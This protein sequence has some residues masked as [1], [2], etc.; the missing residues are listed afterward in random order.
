VVGG[1]VYLFV[2]FVVGQPLLRRI[3][4][5]ADRR[6]GLAPWMLPVMLGM[7]A[8][9]AWFTDIVGIYSVFGAFMLGAAVPRGVLTRDLQGAI[10]PMTTALLVPLYFVYSGLNTKLGLLNSGW[11][12]MLT[13]LVFLAACVGKGLACWAAARLSGVTSRDALGIATLMNARGMMELVLIN[14]ALQRGLI[15]PTLFTI[16]A[17]MAIGTTVMTSPLFALFSPQG[18][19]PGLSPGQA[20]TRDVA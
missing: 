8:L 11:L 3:A 6:N 19:E 5:D 2:V 18:R 10:A 7:L 14:I 1:L 15:T 16:L 9:G 12:W 17:L 4:A 13:M 20:R